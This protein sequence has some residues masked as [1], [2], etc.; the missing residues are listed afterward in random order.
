[1]H[2][3]HRVRRSIALAV[4]LFAVSGVAQ[5]Q[6]FDLGGKTYASIP[7]YLAADWKNDKGLRASFTDGG[8]LAF[9][10]EAQGIVVHGVYEATRERITILLKRR[11]VRDTCAA[12]PV[13]DAIAYPF[14]IVDSNKFESAGEPWERLS[15]R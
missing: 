15:N 14:R 2:C 9:H 7:A 4:A 10:D 6:S 3:H 13:A 12:M 11:C 5:A 1:M 8:I